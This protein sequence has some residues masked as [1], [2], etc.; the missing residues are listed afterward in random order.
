MIKLQKYFQCL[1]LE[2]LGKKYLSLKYNIFSNLILN[3]NLKIIN[4]CF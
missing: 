3:N 2:Y 4:L 1:N